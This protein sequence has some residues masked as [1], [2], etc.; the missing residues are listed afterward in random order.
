MA[1]IKLLD[2]YSLSPL[3]IGRLDRTEIFAAAAHDDDA[4]ASQIGG[5]LGI[6]TPGHTGKDNDRGERARVTAFQLAAQK[7]S[8][9]AALCPSMLEQLSF[10]CVE[11]CS[12]HM[13]P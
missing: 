3:A 12:S 2:N 11:S 9:R 7:A 8:S 5:L 4:P 10:L 6:G 13:S 1:W